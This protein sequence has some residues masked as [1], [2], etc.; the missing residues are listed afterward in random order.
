MGKRVHKVSIITT[1]TKCK[2]KRE[3][4]K[5]LIADVRCLLWFVTLGGLILA[6]YCIYKGYHGTLPWLSAMVGLPWSAHGIICSLYLNMAK[7]DHR[8]GGITFEAAK[9]NNF[10]ALTT[11]TVI[12]EPFKESFTSTTSEESTNSPA[13]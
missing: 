11:P 12:E 3:F 7:S 1:D 2:K 8:E 13:I 5:Q 4:S 6:A 9:A 10:G